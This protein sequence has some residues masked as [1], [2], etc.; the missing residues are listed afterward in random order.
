[1]PNLN[2]RSGD[3]ECEEEKEAEIRPRDFKL[4]SLRPFDHVGPYEPLVLSSP[5]V[6]PVVQVIPEFPFVYI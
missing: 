1:M 6:N 3:D 4:E 2:A 5:G